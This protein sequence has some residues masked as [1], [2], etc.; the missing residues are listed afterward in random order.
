MLVL[1]ASAYVVRT[2]FRL[3]VGCSCTGENPFALVT[4]DDVFE[5]SQLVTSWIIVAAAL[6]RS[7][8]PDTDCARRLRQRTATSPR[9]SSRIVAALVAAYD[10]FELVWFIQTDG[11]VVD[12][13]EPAT[14]SWRGR[15]SLP[16]GW[17]RSGS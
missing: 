15:S 17:C 16:S 1:L 2:A 8:S 11:P 10:A 6:S 3:V 7:S 9:S 4:D 12:L 5:G 14:R 13:G